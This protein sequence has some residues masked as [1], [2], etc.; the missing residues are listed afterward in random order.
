MSTAQVQADLTSWT[1][2]ITPVV[3]DIDTIVFARTS[4]I[5]DYGTG[6]TTLNLLKTTG[7]RYLVSNGTQPWAEVNTSSLKQR[8]NKSLWIL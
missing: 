8:Q 7:F 2:Q 4:N 5:S 1:Q 3:G 6:S